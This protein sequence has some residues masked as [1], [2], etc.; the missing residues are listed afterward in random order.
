MFGIND[1]IAVLY[2]CRIATSEQRICRQ[3][4]AITRL[5]TMG[6]DTTLSESYLCALVSTLRM[7]H[8]HYSTVCLL[9][10]GMA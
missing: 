8:K 4:A 1:Q 7:Y 5:I 10:S 3:E 2:E 9:R 6:Q